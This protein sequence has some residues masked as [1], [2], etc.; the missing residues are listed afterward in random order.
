[1]PRLT[2]LAIVFAVAVQAQA[3]ANQFCALDAPSLRMEGGSPR[4]VATLKCAGAASKQQ[5]R[6]PDGELFVGATLFRASEKY[7]STTSLRYDSMKAAEWVA[8]D[9]Q[10]P[11]DLDAFA[12]HTAAGP[13]EI[14]F[15]IPAGPA[16]T[17]VLLAVWNRKNECAGDSDCPKFGYTLGTPDEDGLPVPIDT[18]P[19]PVCDKAKLIDSGYLTT[20]GPGDPA[21]VALTSSEFTAMFELN[22]CYRLIEGD[23]LGYSLRRW[24]VGPLPAAP[25]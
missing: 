18:W 19:R 10:D 3:R 6:Y 1:M 20:D 22:D 12:I 9:A 21:G 15:Q 25:P 7:K 5:L 11:V 17:H 2:L 4:L 16:F 13:T 8:S 24:R 23:G 14:V